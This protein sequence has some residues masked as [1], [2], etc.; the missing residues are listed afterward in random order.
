MYKSL[1]DLHKGKK[2]Q[3]VY[4]KI[5]ETTGDGETRFAKNAAKPTALRQTP[6]VKCFQIAT[7][8]VLRQDNN[9]PWVARH[10]EQVWPRKGAQVRSS[11]SAKKR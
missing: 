7:H 3:F 6:K 5:R 4:D 1:H 11:Q 8:A 10:L 2:K 9:A